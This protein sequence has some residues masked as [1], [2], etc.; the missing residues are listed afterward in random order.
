[1][2]GKILF[3][4]ST[5]LVAAASALAAFS[6]LMAGPQAVAGFTHVG[7]PQQL[8]IL[9]GIAKPLGAIVLLLPGLPKLKEWRTPASPSRGVPHSW[10][11]TWRETARWH[12]RRWCCWSFS[13]SHMRRALR[14]GSGL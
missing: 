10:R 9:L 3:W 12:F 6:Y 11:I 13:P 7:Y 14:I 4:A 1:M 2:G 5:G 8:R